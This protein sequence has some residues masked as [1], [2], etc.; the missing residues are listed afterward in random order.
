MSTPTAK[1]ELLRDKKNGKIAGICAGIAN[2]FGWEVWLVRIIVVTSFIFGQGFTLILYIAAWFILDEK[3][4]SATSDSHEPVE[5]KTK[6]W[7][8][9]APPHGAFREISGD[10]NDL[11]SR[12]Q[13][14]ETYVTSNAYKLDRELNRL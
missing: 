4:K 3:P 11:E 6:V 1:R 5:L 10:Y 8:A 13:S 7:Q 12:L 14:M 9:G 2:Y